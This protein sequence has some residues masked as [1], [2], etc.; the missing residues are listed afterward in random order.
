[1]KCIEHL[2]TVSIATHGG[3]IYRANMTPEVRG[4]NHSSIHPFYGRLKGST[5]P[6][7]REY[8]ELMNEELAD[9]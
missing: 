5:R 9:S 6:R 4:T 3:Q 7:G 1:M 8:L 2:F